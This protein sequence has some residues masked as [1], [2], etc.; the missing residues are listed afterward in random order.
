MPDRTLAL[1]D[2]LAD[3]ADEVDGGVTVG[4]IVEHLGRRAFGALLFVFSAPNWLPLPPGSSTFLGAPLVLFSPQLMIGVHSPWM[5]G[6]LARRRIPGRSLSAAF[7]RI[8]PWLKKVERLSRPRLT[9]LFGPVGD[10][11]IGL[12]CFLLALVLLLPIPLGNMAPAAAIA[13]LGLGMV[14]RDGVLAIL[15]YLAAAISVGLLVIGAGAALYAARQ[16][17]AAM[18]VA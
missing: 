13:L 4:E 15:G 18:G 7:R 11:L 1:S 2:M 8:I 10:R 3:I 5:P 6:F 16:L 9:F 12:V 17:L 14:Q